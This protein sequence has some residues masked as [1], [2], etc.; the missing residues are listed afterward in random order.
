MYHPNGQK[1]LKL[2]KDEGM[3]N[4]L[5]KKTVLKIERHWACVHDKKHHFMTR[6]QY[7]FKLILKTKGYTV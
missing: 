4:I 5:E 1:Q 6:Q 3:G 7:N 2:P